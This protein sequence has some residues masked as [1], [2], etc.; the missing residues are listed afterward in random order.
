[1]STYNCRRR[2]MEDDDDEVG[3]KRRRGP[4]EYSEVEKKLQDIIARVG[5]RSG[6]ASLESN[7][8]SLCSVL[9]A[10]LDKYRTKI[11]DVISFC[12]TSMPDKLTIYSTLVGLLNAK[13]FNF[14]GEIVEKLISD[15]QEKLE[16]E[17]YQQAMFIVIFLCD[18]GNCRVL[19]LSSIAEFLEGFIQ[20][21][22]ED[23][24]P[25]VR[26]D[27][28]VYTVLHALPWIGTELNDKRKEE[29][30][31]ILEGSE[32]YIEGRRKLY[33]KLLQVWS[34]SSPH[35]QEEYLDSLWAQIKT[36]R[37]ASWH[38]KH[39]ARHYVA[40]DAALQDALQ[41][42]LPSF[43]AP[44]HKDD[45]TYPY[46]TV[47][48][49]LFD[50][51]D[52]P[53]DGPVLPGAHSIER[54]LVEEELCWIIEYNCLDRKACAEELV[55]YAKGA[56]VPISYMIL[57]VIFSQLFR[58]PLP[59]QPPLF[60]GCLLIELCK[61]QP[62]AMPQVLAQAAELL[63]QR[64]STMQPICLDRY[65]DWF[66]YHLSNFQ[67]R[68][69]WS[70]WRDCLESDSWNPK[71][72]FA[73]EVLEKCMRFSYYERVTEFL[74]EE[75]SRLLPAKPEIR[76]TLDDETE[77]GH[78]RARTLMALFQ[79]RVSDE[80]M[81]AE[82]KGEDG[83]FDPKSFA[84]FFAVGLQVYSLFLI[85]KFYF[86]YFLQV[87][88]K[89]ACKSFSHN[90]AALTR[91]H[92]TLKLIADSSEEMQAVVLRTL[93][94][95]WKCNHQVCHKNGQIFFILFYF[96]TYCNFCFFVIKM[97]D[98]ENL[99]REEEDAAQQQEKLDSLRDFQKNL[100][101]DVLHKFTI[102]LTEFIVNCET[103]GTDFR[104][105]WFAWIS[106]RFKQVFLLHCEE[107][108]QFTEALRKE[109]FTNTDIDPNV[110]ETFE[111]FA[112]L[113]AQN[114]DG[115]RKVFAITKIVLV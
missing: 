92:R 94:D 82:L 3:A 65:I 113:R 104:T 101:L 27:W 91:Y 55:N 100:F 70:D 18:L 19:T 86:L 48:F 87:L 93:Y 53:E 76:Y 111:Q 42:N 26:T 23:N 36:L 74:P 11:I 30:D 90:F 103:D 20:A 59:P 44:V 109:L 110:L 10:D 21:A 52:C 108:H 114:K 62:N 4:P 25:Q 8:E 107:L 33:V 39:I 47:V 58:L 41:H 38:E 95:C 1:M 85:F 81:L 24:V 106:G 97:E 83:N 40:F 29:L 89:L 46:P 28:F 5:E 84:I 37:D 50:Y 49:R 9:E 31:N 35:E 17:N 15:L 71:L 88:L 112:A 73:R 96:V 7:L 56:N 43:C 77:E 57:E 54:F 72:I 99:S 69:S 80:T 68:W 13:N 115:R 64:A 60:Y 102:L 32:R 61:L 105:S 75:F 51:A 14:G 67:Y 78:N 63:Y 34:S 66:S 6:N 16:T 98:P 22:Y 79:E 45:S 12:V 2:C